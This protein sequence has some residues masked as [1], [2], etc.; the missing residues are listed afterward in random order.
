MRC[1][2][3]TELARES[4]AASSS[5][6]LVCIARKQLLH[7]WLVLPIQLLYSWLLQ[8]HCS[9]CNI[10]RALHSVC[11]DLYAIQPRTLSSAFLVPI[12]LPKTSATRAAQHVVQVPPKPL[13]L[14]ISCGFLVSPI[15]MAFLQQA[16][17]VFPVKGL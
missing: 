17:S 4:Q 8:E 10:W 5:H 2:D 14:L 9:S 12:Q 15:V 13:K 16:V 7:V 6:A 3:V 1:E 11:Y